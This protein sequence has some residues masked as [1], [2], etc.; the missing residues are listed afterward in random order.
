MEIKLLLLVVCARSSA[1]SIPRH[2]SS[3]PAARWRSARCSSSTTVNADSLPELLTLAEVEAAASRVGCT[4]NIKAVGPTY[5]IELLWDDGN[6]LPAPP[7]QTLGYNDE[8][9][10]PP[11]LLAYSNGFTQPGGVAHLETIEVRKFTGFWARRRAR[12]AE[13][14]AA[15]RPLKPGLLVSLAVAC[16]IRERGAFGNARAQLLAVRDDERQ[17]GALVR[18]YRRLGFVPLREVGSDLRSLAD[19]VAWGGDG[20]IME[21][22]VDGIRRRYAGKVRSLGR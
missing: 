3:R 19:R 20:T 8:P 13:R 5:R 22:D 18:F 15:T 9:P 7:V 1:L 6:R 14:Y 11:S 17:H 10:P 2:S 12:G 4:L 21:I 16:W